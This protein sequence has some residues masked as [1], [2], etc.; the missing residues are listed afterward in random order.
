VRHCTDLPVKQAENVDFIVLK[1]VNALPAA[2]KSDI[3]PKEGKA[4]LPS[5][6]ESDAGVTLSNEMSCGPK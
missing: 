2:I 6:K 5:I 3:L 4:L 1:S